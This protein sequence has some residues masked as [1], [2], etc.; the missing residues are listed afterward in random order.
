[1]TLDV[2]YLTAPVSTLDLSKLSDD[3]L[4]AMIAAREDLEE[5]GN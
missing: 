5:E 3:E 4:R 2:D 1:M